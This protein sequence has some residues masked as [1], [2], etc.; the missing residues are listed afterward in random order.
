MDYEQTSNKKKK[1]LDKNYDIFKKGEVE[2]KENGVYSF[3]FCLQ[4]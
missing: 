4:V 3:S 2:R 1:Y